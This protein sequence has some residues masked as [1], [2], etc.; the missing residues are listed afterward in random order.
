V[1][2]LLD[3]ILLVGV[4]VAAGGMLAFPALT[5]GRAGAAVDTLVATQM[6][7]QRNAIFVDVR[8]A[9][10][11]AA[12]HI[13]Q[14]RSLPLDQIDQKGGTLPKN[15]PLIVVC[16][17]GRTSAG[18]VARLKALGYTDVVVLAGGL[19][20]WQQAGLPVAK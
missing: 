6:V 20:G 12:G 1:Q 14:A 4:A 16:A 8:S 10:D 13:A 17:N 19:A 3:N 11:F 18:A 5:K 9:S 2:F 7:N 15:K